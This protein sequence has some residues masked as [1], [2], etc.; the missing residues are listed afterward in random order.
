MEWPVLRSAN[1][2]TEIA[3]ANFPLIRH[4]KI[5]HASADSPSATV[6]T[7]GWEPASPAT[8]GTFTAIGYY[9]ARD[10]HE[11]IGVPI[12]IVNSTRNG[13]PIESWMSPASLAADPAFAGII[14]R[15]QQNLVG[16]PARSAEYEERLA[17]WTRIEAQARAAVNARVDAALNDR[18]PVRLDP[19]SLYND[20]LQRNP[21]PRAPRGPGDPSAPSGAFNGMI[22][23]LL[24][25]ALRGVLW[26]QGETDAGRASE[27]QALFAAMITGWRAHF[28]QGDFPF[29]WVDLAN[30]AVPADSGERG[31]TYAFLREAQTKTLSLPNTGQ[32]IAIDTGDPKDVHPMNKQNVGRR[33]ALLARN[34]VYAIVADDTGPTFESA[35]REG[36]AMRVRFSHVSGGLVAHEKP[37]QSLELAGVDRVFY[38]ADGRIDRETLIVMS[39]SVREPVA[40]RYAWTNAPE[41]NLYNGAGLPAVPF[42]S[43]AW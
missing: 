39:F 41:A 24:P 1:A 15:W 33:L 8:V 35:T 37:V 30:F 6:N 40:V 11:K 38:P 9:F 18:N 28:A 27:Y 19:H 5:R 4:V 43:D 31:R 23:P 17:G 25:G 7:S 3:A 36:A 13:T 32:A 42:R 22:N 16:Y 34:R 2:H 20:W 14:D 26:Y 21:R 12:G 29:Y 10:I